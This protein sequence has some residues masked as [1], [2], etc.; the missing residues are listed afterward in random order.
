MDGWRDQAVSSNQEVTRT[1]SNSYRKPPLGGNLNWQQSVPSWEKK[2]IASFG[3]VPWKKLVETKKFIHLYDN[4][5]KWNDSAGKE[6]FQSAKNKFYANMHG[7]P[8]DK[9]F[10]DPDIY[11]DKIDWNSQVD[12][13]LILDLESDSVVPESCC[14]DEPVV[15][16]GT[17]FPP[18]YQ[19]FSP[20]GW[21]D[22]DDDD[23]K[24]DPNTSPEYNIHQRETEG[25]TWGVVDDGNNWWG[26]NEDDKTANGD[27]G[28]GN[29][30]DH[31]GWNV[32]DNNNYYYG[33]VNNEMRN[34]SGRSMSRY[35]T[36]RFRRD[37]NQPR[38]NNGN[39][40]KSSSGCRPWKCAPVNPGSAGGGAHRWS[41]KKPVS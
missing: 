19:S 33:D 15:I 1:R 29:R 6:A 38:R 4:V 7:L 32:Y 21:G 23:K 2:F 24:K 10:L 22:S 5:I 11:I 40:K 18:S 14:N 35:K 3:S 39:G 16:F 36:S 27:H 13:N 28:G 26:S 30:N 37:D 34:G 41:V 9:Y 8:S 17:S 31:W 20:Y 25:N 12:P